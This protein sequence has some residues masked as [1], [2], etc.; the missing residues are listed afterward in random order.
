VP[1]RRRS[2]WLIE[3]GARRFGS[4][5]RKIGADVKRRLVDSIGTHA[6][7]PMP[8][9]LIEDMGTKNRYVLDVWGAG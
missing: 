2:G 1:R 8:A 7:M 6:R 3:Q 4:A 9:A 5:R